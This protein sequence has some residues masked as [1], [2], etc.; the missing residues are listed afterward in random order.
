MRERDNTAR[1]IGRASAAQVRLVLHQEND[2]S[3][4]ATGSIAESV[5]WRSAAM[6]GREWLVRA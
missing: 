4:E 5:G 3:D 1:P 2:V 6:E